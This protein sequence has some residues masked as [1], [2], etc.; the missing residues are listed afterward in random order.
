M[1]TDNSEVFTRL[2]DGTL[3]LRREDGSYRPVESQTD[4][5]RLSRMTDSEIEKWSQEDE[6]HPELDDHFWANADIAPRGK[7]AISIKLDSDI[8][9]WFKSHGKGY[10]TRMNEVLRI[11][12]ASQKSAA[13]KT[14]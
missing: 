11:Y 5:G 7:T 12:V 13:K 9:G 10:Q 8:L 14:G 4:I 2:S 3:L 1:K 6:D